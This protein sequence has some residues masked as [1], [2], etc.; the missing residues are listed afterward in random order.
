MTTTHTYDALVV[1]A[2]GAGLRAAIE[3]SARCRT[4]VISK[5]YPTRSHTGAAQGGVCAALGNVEEDSPEWHAFDTVKGGDYLVDQPAALLMTEEAIEAI[6]QLERWGLP[7]NRTADGRIDQRRFGGHTRNHGEAP[8][9]RACYAADRTGHMILQ[10]LY[11]QCVKRDVRFFNE[12]YCLDLLR[13]DAG[14]TAGIVAYELATGELHVFRAKAVLFA[15]GGYGR[16]FRVTSNAHALTGDGPAVVW[17]RGIPLE[18][19]EMFQFHP[20][21]LARLGVLLSEAARGEG[22][23]VLNSEGERFMERYAPTIKD[24]APRDMVSRAIYQEIK[25]GRG[26]GPTGDWV[27]LDISHLDPKVIEEKLPDITEFARIY[28]KVEPMNEPVPIQPTAHYAM[29]GIPTD[30]DGRVVVGADEAVVPG[31]YA[32]GECACVSVHGANRLGTNSLLDLVVFGRRAGDDAARYIGE[33]DL[34]MPPEHPERPTLELLDG[35]LGRTTGDNAGEIRKELQD[36]MF[37]LAFVVRS[38]ESLTKMQQILASLRERYERVAIT[39]KGSLYNTDLMETVELGYLLDCADAL[40]AG[41]LVRTESRGAHFR[42]DHPLR[43]D[44]NWLKHTLATREQDGTIRIE[45]KP[46]K[47]GPYVPMERKY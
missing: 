21:G 16:M 34:A 17:R 13:D 8:V 33:A 28:L 22:G 10:T 47:M 35:I 23:I 3:L 36:N 1:G 40:V 26:G 41:A 27:Y 37:D 18:D 38:N 42:E 46:V 14:T 44:A 19:M 30:T 2:G 4:A 20:T 31:L 43:D 12:F 45:Y 15:T 39:D 32:A 29:G 24:L 6:Y 9:K 5:L 7:F 11:Q 25:E